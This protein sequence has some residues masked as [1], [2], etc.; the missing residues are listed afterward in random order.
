MFGSWYGI[1]AV[2]AYRAYGNSSTLQIAEELWDMSSQYVITTEDAK[3]GSHPFKTA[4]IASACNGCESK[5]HI[6]LVNMIQGIYS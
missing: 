3:K 6:V 4:P 2:D 1:T 5:R